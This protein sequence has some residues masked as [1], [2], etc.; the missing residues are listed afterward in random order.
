MPSRAPSPTSAKPRWTYDDLLAALRRWRMLFGT[1][2]EPSQWNFSA[3]RRRGDRRL[4]AR[5]EAGRW[6]DYRT[7]LREFGSWTVAVAAAE[8]SRF[9]QLPLRGRDPI[10]GGSR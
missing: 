2:P 3:A 9:D 4:L 8:E 7:V 1:Y 10:P 5:L 6:P